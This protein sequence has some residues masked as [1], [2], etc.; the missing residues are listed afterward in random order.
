MRPLAAIAILFLA[1]SPIYESAAPVPEPILSLATQF[2]G[3]SPDEVRD[4]ISKRFGPYHRDTGSGLSIPQWDVFG[5]VLT[6]HPHTGPFFY[7]QRTKK[8]TGLIPTHNAVRE[9]LLQSYEMTSHADQH[10]NTYWLGNLDFPTNTTY[11]FTKSGLHVNARNFFITYP[12]GTVSVSL[13]KGITDERPL[14]S[15]SN[16]F[17]IAQIV[18][19]SA[20]GTKKTTYSIENSEQARGLEFIGVKDIGFTMNTSWKNFWK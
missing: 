5:G 1:L 15:V 14:E 16:R 13:A 17:V 19:T 8:V 7:D 10:G 9:N 18:F 12:T 20:D 6:F 4:L 11:R 2:R 3:K